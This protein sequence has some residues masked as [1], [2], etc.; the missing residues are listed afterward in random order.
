MDAPGYGYAKRSRSISESFLKMII[1]FINESQPLKGI[2][3]LIDFKVGPTTL[4]IDWI[5]Q[6]KQ[7]GLPIGIIATKID[8]I[9][10]TKRKK[11]SLLIHQTLGIPIIGVSNTKRINIHLAKQLFET[12]LGEGV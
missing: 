6:V 10:V 4:D 11:Q 7:S 1:R 12:I 8:K 9:P 2:I 3:V 5:D